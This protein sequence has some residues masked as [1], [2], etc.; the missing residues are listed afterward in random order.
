MT[1][2]IE[3]PR[4]PG[5]QPSKISEHETLSAARKAAKEFSANR[6]DLK[7]HDVRIDRPDG[8]LVEYAGPT[9]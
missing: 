2:T 7:R 5:L 1:Y 4:V 9:R 6:P 8:H 3:A